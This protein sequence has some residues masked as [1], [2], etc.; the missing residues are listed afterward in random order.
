MFALL[1]LVVAGCGSSGSV[2]RGNPV[3]TR[4]PPSGAATLPPATRIA[5]HR[6][7]DPELMVAL[8]AWAAFPVNV[9][10]RALVLTSDPVTAP[11][12][13]FL[14]T[15]LKEA[16]LSGAFLD[17]AV[18]PAGPARAGGYPVVGARDALAVLRAEGSP[19][20]GAPAPPIP[21]PI[22]GVRFG[23]APF[24]TDRGTRSL[25]VWLFSLQGVHDPAAVWR[26]RHH[27]DST[28]RPSP[29]TVKADLPA[30]G[31]VVGLS[32]L[33]SWGLRPGLDL[34]PRTTPW[35]RPPRNRHRRPRQDD[36]PE[37]RNG[38]LLGGRSPAPHNHHPS[39]AARA[40]SAHRCHHQRTCHHR[41]VTAPRELG[42]R[43]GGC[44]PRVAS[45]AGRRVPAL[46]LLSS[47]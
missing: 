45:P 5:R 2:A 13:G 3:T 46:L 23:A 24:S 16:F 34:A 8:R 17:P 47:S 28:R 15:E 30:S 19:A 40:T 44:P 29:S 35:T 7:P 9:R 14:T 36:P 26:W 43:D 22:T 4:V 20:N 39:C 27:R 31:P 10:P 38:C 42:G 18:F 32:R 33:L 12:R 6:R 41:G 37:Q 1:A 25:P 11:S 21:L